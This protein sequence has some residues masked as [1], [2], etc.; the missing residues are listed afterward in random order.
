MKNTVQMYNNF[1]TYAIPADILP[2]RLPLIA[3]N[4]IVAPAY[5]Q[6]HCRIF[7]HRRAKGIVSQRDHLL[8]TARPSSVKGGRHFCKI[9]FADIMP[10]KQNKRGFAFWRDQILKSYKSI[11]DT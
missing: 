6:A 4:C 5:I 7:V 3:A 9:G 8:K 10:K 2:T 11:S 1:L